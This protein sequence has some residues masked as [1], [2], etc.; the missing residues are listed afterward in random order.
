MRD[1]DE[2]D[3][4]TTPVLRAVKMTWA[5]PAMAFLSTMSSIFD[6]IAE[7]FS[8]LSLGMASHIKYQADRRD[9][10]SS[11]GYDIERI[12]EGKNA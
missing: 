11:V 10:A 2:E 4:E 3:E 7:G 6:A 8:D 12:T 9:F 5:L 1:S